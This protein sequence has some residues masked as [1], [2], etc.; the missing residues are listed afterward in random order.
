MPALKNHQKMFVVQRLAW[1]DSPT[2]VANAVKDEFN[3]VVDRSQIA[4]YDPTTQSGRELGIKLQEFFF[5]QRR[6]FLADIEQIPLANKTVR[7][8]EL[9]KLFYAARQRNNT[10]LAAS[11]CEQIAKEVGNFY[12]NKTMLGGDRE[13]PFSVWLQ[14]IGG[15]SLPIVHDIDDEA[16]TIDHQLQSEGKPHTVASKPKRKLIERD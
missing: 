13:N 7:V 16:V 15:S 6:K 12:T 9:S 8:R 10:V 1:F 4:Q 5:D 2:E 11:L 3:L 14:Q